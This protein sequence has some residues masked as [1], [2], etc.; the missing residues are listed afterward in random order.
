MNLLISYFGLSIYYVI[1]YDKIGKFALGGYIFMWGAMQN[2]I[3]FKDLVGIKS[4]NGTFS[5][6]HHIFGISDTMI[7]KDSYH[8]ILDTL[9]L[10]ALV[11]PFSLLSFL[12]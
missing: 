6:T 9:I 7:I 10:V 1:F 3:Y 2:S 8:Y 12:L 4:Y 5:Q 11:I